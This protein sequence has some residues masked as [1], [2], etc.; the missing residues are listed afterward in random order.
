VAQE[1][2]LPYREIG[3]RMGMPIGSIGPT[4]ARLL[5]KLEGSLAVQLLMDDEPVDIAIAA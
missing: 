1:P 2:A 3:R 4:R 5:K